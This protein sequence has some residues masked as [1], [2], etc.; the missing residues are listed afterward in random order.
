MS[1]RR[2]GSVCRSLFGPV[3]HDQLRQD[4]DLQ[5]QEIT[6]QDS[7]R[8]N[9][10]FQS[11]T[12]LSG[13]FEWEALSAEWEAACTLQLCSRTQQEEMCDKQEHLTG[14]DQENCSGI[15]NSTRSPAEGNP[16][17]MKRSKHVAEP[18]TNAKITGKTADPQICS[19]CS[20]IRYI[21]K[22]LT[23]KVFSCFICRFFH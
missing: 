19:F 11:E 17:Q 6:V 21:L 18:R 23:R 12:P 15:S 3:D 10:C 16:V 9:F 22:E 7:Q 5:L 4:L 1:S 2:R 14:T 8:W 13:R 20:L